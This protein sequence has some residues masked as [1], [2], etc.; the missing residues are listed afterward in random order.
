MFRRIVLLQAISSCL[1]GVA[2]AGDGD[3]LPEF[4]V[5]EQPAAWDILRQYNSSGLTIAHG[6]VEGLGAVQRELV[7]PEV[8][9]TTDGVDLTLAIQ[10]EGNADGPIQIG[11]FKSARWDSG[12]PA[13]VRN[14][15][16]AGIHTLMNIPPGN[17]YLGAMIGK[18]PE[19]TTVGMHQTWPAPVVVGVERRAK[20]RLLIKS[21]VMWRLDDISPTLI[22]DPTAPNPLIQ[23]IDGQGNPQPRCSITLSAKQVDREIQLVGTTNGTFATNQPQ[24]SQLLKPQLS[25]RISELETL[26]D[27]FT[28]RWRVTRQSVYPPGDQ[29]LRITTP[30]RPIGTGQVQGTVRDQNGRPLTQFEVGLIM[31]NT[32]VVE[33]TDTDGNLVAILAPILDAAGRFHCRNLPPGD[34][35]ANLTPADTQSFSSIESVQFTVSEDDATPVQLDMRVEAKTSFYGFIE[36][37][38]GINIEDVA[39]FFGDREWSRMRWGNPFRISLSAAQRSE[40]DDSGRSRLRIH[41]K[42]DYSRSVQI[43]YRKLSQDKDNPTILKLVPT[44]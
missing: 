29:V 44:E 17:Y 36:S 35:E 7:E 30:Q 41:A 27:S 2:V 8:D 9:K 40:F 24:I 42:G 43:D 34:Y 38:D 14:V 16:A 4:V 37:D 12:R 3:P 22:H 19:V 25:V 32:D 1:T 13:F 26:P 21:G 6:I 28:T 23:V 39:L 33:S 5:T 11:F 18:F 31:G 15:P 10:Q 20:A